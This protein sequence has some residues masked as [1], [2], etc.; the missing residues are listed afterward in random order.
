M[1]NSKIVLPVLLGFSLAVAAASASHAA[2]TAIP[3][4]RIITASGTY[5]LSGNMSVATAAGGITINAGVNN[6]TIDMSGFELK[7]TTTGKGNGIYAPG[8]NTN[9]NI[10]NGSI[11]GFW[12]GIY[13]GDTGNNAHVENA[14]IE[15][16]RFYNNSQDA[17]KLDSSSGS[18]IKNCV[19]YGNN[20]ESQWGIHIGEA[21][22]LPT[23]ATIINNDIINMHIAISTYECVNCVIESNRLS[24]P[25]GSVWTDP[26]MQGSFGIEADG[27]DAIIENNRI[28]NFAIGI[29]ADPSTSKFR[30]N[31]THWCTTPYNGPALIDAGNNW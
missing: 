15:G 13:L 1:N 24:G 16:V 22:P 6:V 10:K 14:V 5:C 4:N 19:M 17:I 20:R 18:L 8:A 26:P 31:T 9:I 11:N 21:G 27:S 3:T 2:C 30:N 28:S 25:K 29:Q 23:Q 7:N 12:N